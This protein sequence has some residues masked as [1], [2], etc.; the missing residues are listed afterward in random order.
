M[1]TFLLLS[2][3][4]QITENNTKANRFLSKH[5]P[6]YAFRTLSNHTFSS[7]ILNALTEDNLQDV[8]KLQ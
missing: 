6:D 5:T 4:I 2:E 7:V 3:N 8:T 1:N